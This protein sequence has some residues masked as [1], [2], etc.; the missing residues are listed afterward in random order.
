[1]LRFARN[2]QPRE[3]RSEAIRASPQTFLPLSR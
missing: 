3:K 1:L 2:E